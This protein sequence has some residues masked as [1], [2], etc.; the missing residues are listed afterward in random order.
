M[1]AALQT[2]LAAARYCA[3]DFGGPART[4]RRVGMP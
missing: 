4:V 1:N 2:G 3:I